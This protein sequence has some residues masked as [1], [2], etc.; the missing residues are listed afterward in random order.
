M[1]SSYRSGR[2]HFTPSGWHTVTPRIVA[3]EAEQLVDFVKYVFG[4]TGEYRPDMPAVLNIGDS[5]VMISD[6]GV[7]TLHRVFCM[8][9][10]RM[11][12]GRIGAPLMLAPAPSKSR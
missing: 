6:A 10:S 7:R 12:T 9:T 11:P 3:L 2:S 4:A 5:I 8:C 1:T